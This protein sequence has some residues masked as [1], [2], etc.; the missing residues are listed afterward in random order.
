MLLNPYFS[1]FEKIKL[2][3]FY[4]HNLNY[5]Q[6]HCKYSLDDL[7]LWHSLSNACKDC[8]YFPRSVGNIF[9]LQIVSILHYKCKFLRDHNPLLTRTLLSR[10]LNLCIIMDLSHIFGL[11]SL[12]IVQFLPFINKKLQFIFEVKNIPLP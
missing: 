3:T 7:C 8:P 2:M 5:P 10:I 1:K 12:N 4:A 6:N 11:H 9:M